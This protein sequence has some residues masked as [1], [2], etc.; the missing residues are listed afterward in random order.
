VVRGAGTGAE[1]LQKVSLKATGEKVS[2]LFDGTEQLISL[3]SLP[4]YARETYLPGS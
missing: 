4:W 1:R 3:I 2:P